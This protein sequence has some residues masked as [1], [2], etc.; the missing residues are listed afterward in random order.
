[1]R[2]N[3]TN[4]KPTSSTQSSQQEKV[5]HSQSNETSDQNEI[6]MISLIYEKVCGI[7]T[8]TNP[9]VFF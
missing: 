5:S 8:V 4:K 2:N 9:V 7:E 3:S 6:D 1:M